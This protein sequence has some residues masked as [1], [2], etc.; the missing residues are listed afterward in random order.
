MMARKRRW[1]SVWRA[2]VAVVVACL[3]VGGLA[4]GGSLVAFPWTPIDL[5]R[6]QT[7]FAQ[8]CATCHAV[9]PQTRAALGPNLAQ[10]GRVASGRVAG[11]TAEE[12]L[13]NSILEPAAFRAEGG[14]GLMPTDV[15]AGLS[16]EDVASLVGYLM[17]LGGEPSPR[18][19]VHLL[20]RIQ[21]LPAA[22]AIPVDFVQ[23]EAGRKL[24]LGKAG[25][26]RC[27]PLQA[28]P[29]HGLRAPSLVAAGLHDRAYLKRSIREP[30]HEITRDYET[31][32]VVLTTGKVLTGRLL[33]ED[34]QRVE[35]L[36]EES[37]GVVPRIIE[38]SAL[39]PQEPAGQ[40]LVRLPTSLM[41]QGLAEQLS[42]LEIEQLVTFL[43]TL[44][45]DLLK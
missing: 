41:P 2:A 21:T 22:E 39:E 19:L 34:E 14:N 20:P 1:P 44:R 27:H 3:V 38:K 9:E 28:L 40:L 43:K 12:Y 24:F 26:I 37:G 7:V 8:R 23:A 42:D 4:V 5:A 6:G 29:G 33:A 35:L 13:L 32:Q 11:Q 25:C 31:W 18:A 36:V 15:S 10:I 16:A 30:H 17:T 45:T